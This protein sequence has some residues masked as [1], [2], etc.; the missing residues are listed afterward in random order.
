M[1]CDDEQSIN[2]IY[3]SLPQKQQLLKFKSLC[4]HDITSI[5]TP[6]T[7]TQVFDEIGF[8]F[9]AKIYIEERTPK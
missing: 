2:P 5:I 1:N 8:S 6:E 3:A 4:F 7:L 9:F